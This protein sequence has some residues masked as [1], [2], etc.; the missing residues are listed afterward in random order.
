MKASET[1]VPPKRV[2]NWLTVVG[3]I[4]AAV[5]AAVALG[6]VREQ[7]IAQLHAINPTASAVPRSVRPSKIH[8]VYVCFDIHGDSELS[9]AYWRLLPRPHVDFTK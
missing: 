2:L 8:G 7:V 3:L 4:S 6:A 1:E 9:Y 5:L